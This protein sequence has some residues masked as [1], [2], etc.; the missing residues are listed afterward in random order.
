MSLSLITA[1]FV[2]VLGGS[3]GDAVTAMRQQAICQ[4]GD[5]FGR[6]DVLSQGEGGISLRI[7]T[8]MPHQALTK[9][10]QLFPGGAP[11][12]IEEI[13]IEQPR[14][15]MAVVIDDLGMKPDQIRPFWRMEQAITYAIMPSQPWTRVY[16]NWLTRHFGSIIVHVPMEPNHKGHITFKGYLTRQQTTAERLKLFRQHLSQVPGAIGFNNHMGSALTADTQAMKELLTA[17]P[18]SWLVLDS[19]TSPLSKLGILAKK[20]FPTALRSFFLDNVRTYS[21][22]LEQFEAGLAMALVS[23]QSIVIGH[24]YRETTTA[25]AD[26]IRLHGKRIHIVPI[27][28]VTSP[29]TKPLW[30]RN[31]PQ[32]DGHGR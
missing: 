27:E 19:R 11:P 4:V 31:C 1:L 22:I 15:M 14:P 18:P 2:T 28:R 24:P 9:I 5:R 17:V 25:L 6:L 3:S 12:G 32:T 30:L 16:A 20:R 7:V 23:G 8:P 10:R 21:R 29:P 26:F 13:I